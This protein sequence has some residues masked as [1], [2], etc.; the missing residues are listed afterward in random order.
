[1]EESRM[2]APVCSIRWNLQRC[3]WT[4]SYWIEKFSQDAKNL[5]ETR[6]SSM[7]RCSVVKRKKWSYIALLHL[8][9]LPNGQQKI[10]KR[11]S[12][13]KKRPIF[14]RK[15][16]W[17]MEKHSFGCQEI[18]ALQLFRLQ[19]RRSYSYERRFNQKWPT[20]YHCDCARWPRNPN[21]FASQHI[22]H[23]KTIE[24]AM[25]CH[26]SSWAATKYGSNKDVEKKW[27]ENS[28]KF[29][30]LSSFWLFQPIF[31]E[32]H[33]FIFHLCRRQESCCTAS[34]CVFADAQPKKKKKKSCD[35]WHAWV[36]FT[37]CE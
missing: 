37:S 11:T 2:I 14:E 23:T 18:F 6:A 12:N 13:E 5:T 34:C 35:V 1:M 25:T 16:W 26:C 19:P 32:I 24:T 22:M 28:Q 9:R 36:W 10:H 4:A 17:K 31:L 30:E 8:L 33:T 21:N 20:F 3:T 27:H 29:S 7:H 15:W